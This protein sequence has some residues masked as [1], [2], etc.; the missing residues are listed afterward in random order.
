MTENDPKQ[1]DSES[2]Q[3]TGWDRVQ[4]ALTAHLQPAKAALAELSEDDLATVVVDEINRRRLAEHS[5]LRDT[6]G[7]YEAAVT[8]LL[9]LLK[10]PTNVTIT[11]ANGKI[12]V[13]DW[14]SRHNAKVVER[15]AK[16]ALGA[17]LNTKK[18]DVVGPI[19]EIT[20]MVEAFVRSHRQDKLD[21]LMTALSDRFGCPIDPEELG[22]ALSAP[23]VNG[24]VTRVALAVGIIDGDP[25]EEDDWRRALDTVRD[26]L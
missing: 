20:P 19:R 9:A 26:A 25:E 24:R 15:L 16:V 10:V 11:A 4:Q 14:E 12:V 18:Q 3:A 8:A 17:R 13:D 6:P 21:L 22:V 23:T 7:L 1:D 5:T 2:K